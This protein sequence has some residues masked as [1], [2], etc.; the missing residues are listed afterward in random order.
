VRSV[1]M[2]LPR[3]RHFLDAA[4]DA[5]RAEPGKPHQTA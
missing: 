3:G 5:M 1:A 2:L 4:A